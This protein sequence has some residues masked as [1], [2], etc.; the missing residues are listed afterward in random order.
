MTSGNATQ[1]ARSKPPTQVSNQT[2]VVGNAL[3]TV[4]PSEKGKEEGRKQ[5]LT[6]FSH[7]P[8]QKTLDQW[9]QKQATPTTSQS[10]T[11][12]LK[13]TP[14]AASTTKE[15]RPIQLDKEE[16]SFYTTLLER[17]ETRPQSVRDATSKEWQDT[18]FKAL[19]LLAVKDQLDRE[20]IFDS[21]R[22]QNEWAATTAANYWSAMLT[23]ANILGV[24]TT[25]ASRLKGRVLSYLAKEE[26]PKRKT[27]PLTSQH[28]I[29]LLTMLPPVLAT[30]VS[31]SFRI[32]QRMGDTFQL[33]SG[34][35]DPVD[36]RFAQ[37]TFLSLC[38]KHGKTTRRRQPFC[39]HLPM[40]DSLSAALMNLQN[41]T[42]PG[43]LL[44]LSEFSPEAAFDTIKQA[45]KKLNP[46]YSILSIRRGGL[47]EMALSG[48]SQATLLHHSRHSSVETLHRYLEWGKLA[49]DAAR[50]RFATTP[51][52]PWMERAITFSHQQG[53]AG[54]NTG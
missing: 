43:S 21:W 24:E 45:L 32:G 36:D 50:E 39:L 13:M 40:E 7:Q 12:K 18:Q 19:T 53:T 54:G 38:Y 26:D 10:Q 11:S 25:L 41:S 5:L 29:E 1:T 44:F 47:Q 35:L 30:A 34:A 3:Q 16:M 8:A 51:K 9:L 46:N 14:S 6:S 20:A 42:P 15:K 17:W 49:L 28:H 27:I 22:D 52:F 23:A 37:M 33:R 4:R 48:V 2:V 31:T